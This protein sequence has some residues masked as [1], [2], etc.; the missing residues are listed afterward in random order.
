MTIYYSFSNGGKYCGYVN[1]PD[2]M[3][4]ADMSTY[5]DVAPRDTDPATGA[6]Q[7]YYPAT[8]TWSA[9]AA[10]NAAE[11]STPTSTTTTTT[12]ES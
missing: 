2:G 9:P 4:L 5:T 10:V 7:V 6:D 12:G 1:L 11:T 3:H 8:K